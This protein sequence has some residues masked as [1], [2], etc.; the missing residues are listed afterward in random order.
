MFRFSNSYAALPS[1]ADIAQ[2]GEE[3]DEGVTD[4]RS[5]CE[6]YVYN[7]SGDVPP[8][9]FVTLLELYSHLQAGVSIASWMETYAVY[10]K[11]IDVRRMVQFGVIKG[12]LRRVH[13]YPVWLD[14]PRIVAPS[15]QQ[16][17]G[18]RGSQ[19][20]RSGSAVSMPGQSIDS[21][22]AAG[23]SMGQP[24]TSSFFALPTTPS[25]SNSNDVTPRPSSPSRS[26]ATAI[27]HNN[28]APLRRTRSPHVHHS[29]PEPNGLNQQQQQH[30][31]P[32]YPASLPLLFDGSHHVDEICV[33]YGVSLGQLQVVMRELGGAA[34]TNPS[35]PTSPPPPTASHDD[36]GEGERRG[37]LS[38]YSYGPRM[39]VMYV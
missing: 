25:T 37:S 24:G 32:S 29:T 28:N 17:R 6:A 39:V 19:G 36:G 18:S 26:R 38:T 34:K 3:D 4:L 11:P 35:S 9:P 10:S 2:Y 12:F 16:S 31:G 30:Q 15:R 33:R 14:H 20:A 21:V 1:I 22:T 13:A 8:V 5:E 23:G 7:G 27:N